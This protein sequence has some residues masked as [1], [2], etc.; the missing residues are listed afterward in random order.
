MK[1]RTE[2]KVGLFALIS[3]IL[4]GY[5]IVRVGDRG[6]VRG[7]GYQ[8]SVVIDSAEGLIRKTPVEVA[9]IK[10]GFVEKLDLVEGRRAKATLRLDGRVRLGED[11]EATVRSKGFLGETYVNLN[12][13]DP[14][15]G[16]IPE[17]GQIHIV[18]S[19]TD[20]GQIVTE[21]AGFLQTLR[22]LGES[23]EENVEKILEGLARFSE[24]LSVIFA[25]RKEDIGETL[26]RLSSISKKIDEGR[27]TVGRLVNDNEIAENISEAARG[28]SMAVGGVARF[29]FGFDYHLE[30]LGA[31][32][33]YKNYVGLVLKP[34]PD[35]YFRLDFVVDPEPSPNQTITTT[36]TTTGGV[37]TTTVAD[38]RV[39]NRDDF[40]ISAQLAKSFYDFTVRAG[41]IE[42]RGGGGIDWEHGPLKVEFSA[43]DFR[44]MEGQRPHLKALG[45]FAVT[46]NIFV[47]SGL[48]DFITNEHDPDWFV[49]G[50]FALVDEDIKSLFSA[51]ALSAVKR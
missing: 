6:S 21:A 12:P 9:G 18:N 51:A 15:K 46:K 16:E 34:R 8:V 7:E 49:G 17:G 13:G 23:N 19:Y 10:V 2:I 25:D 36:M 24:D 38:E 11:A 3:L 37:S 47:V 26:D 20:M 43:F 33:D 22:R 35:K 31:T 39:I 50:G 48:D 27:G 1:T 40:R 42:S 30:Y 41:V 44:T 29:Q 45:R 14:A 28:V 4:V 5:V 32:K